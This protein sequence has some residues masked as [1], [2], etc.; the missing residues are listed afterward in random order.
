MSIFC[1][2]LGFANNIGSS[3][4]V[5]IFEHCSLYHLLNTCLSKF[6]CDI[7]F[8]HP[9]SAFD[10][11]NGFTFNSFFFSRLF[12]LFLSFFSFFPCQSFHRKRFLTMHQ[13]YKTSKDSLAFQSYLWWNNSVSRLIKKRVVKKRKKRE[14][15]TLVTR[16]VRYNNA[17]ICTSR[18]CHFL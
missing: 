1:L 4:S 17:H 9:F 13:P 5:F 15:Q 7:C 10:Q 6:S 2:S 16:Y 18:V 12:F 14:K 3:F 8:L 11:W